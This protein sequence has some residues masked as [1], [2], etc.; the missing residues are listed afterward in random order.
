MIQSIVDYVSFA[1]DQRKVVSDRYQSDLLL[2]AVGH[3][4]IVLH[5]LNQ[6]FERYLWLNHLNGL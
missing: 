2:S 4:E 5:S 1:D 6:R 3:E